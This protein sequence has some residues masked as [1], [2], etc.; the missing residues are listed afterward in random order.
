M[1]EFIMLMIFIL[2]LNMIWKLYKLENKIDE[3]HHYLASILD[4]VE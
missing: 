3:A 1:L 4:E 2:Q